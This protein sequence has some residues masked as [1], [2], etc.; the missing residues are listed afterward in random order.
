M[1]IHGEFY[2]RAAALSGCRSGVAV[3]FYAVLSLLKNKKQGS[4]NMKR[5]VF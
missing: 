4:K 1:E 2:A 5:A 3:W